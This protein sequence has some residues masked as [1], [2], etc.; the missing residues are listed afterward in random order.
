MLS[1]LWSL[2]YTVHCSLTTIMKKLTASDIALYSFCP[3]AWTLKQLGYKSGNLERME[4]GTEYH[5][6][7]GRR[8]KFNRTVRSVLWVL[9]LVVLT[10]AAAIII[11]R[12]GS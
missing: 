10:A 2:L 1:G 7:Y 12:I 6:E 5:D 3:R 8:L 11:W 9:L 4:A